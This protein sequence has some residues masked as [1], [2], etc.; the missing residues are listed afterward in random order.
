MRSALR[1]LKNW[2]SATSRRACERADS[3]RL[4]QVNQEV[5][6]VDR[7]HRVDGRDRA[8]GREVREAR[9]VAAVGLDRR[10]RQL[11]L[12]PQVVEELLDGQVDGRPHASML[13]PHPAVRKFLTRGT[14]QARPAARVSGG[15][16][17]R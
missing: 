16:S 5:E 8:P 17:G 13:D 2:R 7:P 1:N 6:D 9:Q 11:P 4:G 12:D 10:R 15:G 3:L 14:R